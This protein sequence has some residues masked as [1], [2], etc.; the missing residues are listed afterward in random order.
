[1]RR[2][3][4]IREALRVFDGG[5]K[6]RWNL[7]MLTGMELEHVSRSTQAK[8]QEIVRR[9]PEDRQLWLTDRTRIWEIEH[10]GVRYVIAG[11]EWRV[12]WDR[13]KRQSRIEAG[14]EELRQIA[15]A[16]RK[17]ADRALLGSRVGRALQRLQAHKYFQ[18]GVDA[19]GRF[20]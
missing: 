11:G 18:Y 12:P 3:L 17:G 6:S 15:K 10:Q 9:L 14:E 20:W 4:G 7:E 2:R 19:K 16:T 1:M 5:M 8:L 13:E